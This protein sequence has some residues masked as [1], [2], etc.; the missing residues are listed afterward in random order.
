MASLLVVGCYGATWCHHWL[1]RTTSAQPVGWVRSKWSAAIAFWLGLIAVLSAAFAVTPLWDMRLL[2]AISP[3][4]FLAFVMSMLVGLAVPASEEQPLSSVV[5]VVL[6]ALAGIGLYLLTDRL[7]GGS[8][9]VL[10]S[11]V[12][13]LAS[14]GMVAYVRL[15]R[16]RERDLVF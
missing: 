7:S 1:F 4:L 5:G 6:A 14:A 9:V 2:V 13:T 8:E 16:W 3:Q 15:A 11:L 12:G 10:L